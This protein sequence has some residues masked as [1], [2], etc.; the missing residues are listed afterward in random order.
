VSAIRSFA[1]LLSAGLP[2]GVAGGLQLAAKGVGAALAAFGEE[3][4]VASGNPTQ[5]LFLR[6]IYAGKEA[7]ASTR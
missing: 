2:G 7:S 3:R 5:T 6:D 4:P 1:G